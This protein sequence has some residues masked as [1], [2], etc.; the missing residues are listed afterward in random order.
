MEFFESLDYLVKIGN[1][2]TLK[3]KHKYYGQVQLGMAILGL[4]CTKLILYSS[5]KKNYLSINVDFN[6]NFTVSLIKKI[7]DNYFQNMLHFFCVNK[8]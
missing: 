7:T 6:K 3:Q 4:S 1:E 5:F 8:I 2:V